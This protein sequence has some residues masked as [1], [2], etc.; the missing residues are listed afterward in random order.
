MLVFDPPELQEKVLSFIKKLSF[1]KDGHIEDIEFKDILNI[2]SYH[3]HDC[4]ITKGSDVYFYMSGADLPSISV[5]DILDILN[6]WD[7]A[8]INEIQSYAKYN[9]GVDFLINVNDYESIALLDELKAATHDIVNDVPGGTEL[10]KTRICV[11][12]K[13]YY[14]SLFN[15]FCKYHLLVEK[16]GNFD[17]Y[18]PSFSPYD[19]FVRVTRDE[20]S[21]KTRDVTSGATS[22]ER[23]DMKIADDLAIAY[24]FELYATHNLI[25]NFSEGRPDPPYHYD[26]ENTQSNYQIFSLLHGRG[27]SELLKIYNTA[28]TTY[29]IDYKILSFTKV[30]EYI[31]PTIAQM[32]L[33][34]EVQLKLT[35]ADVFSPTSK[36]IGELG[37]I[38]RKY[39]N[40][41]NK[42]SEL[43]RL[44]VA[45]LIK[46]SDVW[47]LI[48]E[49]LKPKNVDQIDKLDE[50]AEELCLSNLIAAIYDTRNEIAHAK[51]NYEK[52]GNECPT[53]FKE[54]FCQTLDAIAVRCIRWFS[55]QPENRRVVATQ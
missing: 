8:S 26:N 45:N 29:N 33:F 21:D 16:S 25:F 12:Q 38:Y 39:Q 19:Y 54:Q 52:K 50:T 32:K 20:K 2:D 49:Y 17:K 4:V 46:L 31:S 18:Y 43:I 28:K 22:D 42:D 10:W 14:V 55:V 6:G 24:A 36:Y 11:A 30:I 23:I 5:E 53:K 13:A 9:N 44:A 48:P 27:I 51:A 35:D 1:L 7:S 41:A 40:D 47:D 15:G 37:E 34:D 3:N